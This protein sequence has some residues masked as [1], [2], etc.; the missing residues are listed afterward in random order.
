M[1][2]EDN[3]GLSDSERAQL[4]GELCAFME[5]HPARAPF[6]LRVIDWM[7]A[8]ASTTGRFFAA[9]YARSMA[10]AAVLIVL[11]G[12]GTSYAAESAL[13]GDS[14]Y[15]VKI[16][17][18]EKIASTLAV[19]PEAHVH[20]AAQLADRRLQE[21]ERLAADGRLS[22]REG[23]E[24]ESNLNAATANFDIHIAA[25][26]TS[27]QSGAAIAANVQSE[28]EANFSAH[29]QVLAAIS[30][31]IPKNSAAVDSLEVAVRN[32][33]AKVRFARTTLDTQ[34][35]ASSSI[36]SVEDAKASG[37]NATEAAESAQLLVP[38]VAANLG[39]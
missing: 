18:N 7:E 21:A 31:A 35:A 36:P 25:L 24:V 4:R 6:S 14:L 11:V 20:F 8:S 17:I 12:G 34:L 29:A 28:L 9:S 22:S 16:G 33:L 1:R 13:P 15:A 30:N 39:A 19:S 38:Q 10:S 37:E 23:V 26:A 27:S 3:K 2:A 5:G 32:H